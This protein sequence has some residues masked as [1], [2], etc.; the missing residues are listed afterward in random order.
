LEINKKNAGKMN[1]WILNHYAATPDLATGTRHYDFGMELS[2]RGHNITVFAS[3]FLPTRP[4]EKCP[5]NRDK[6]L[7]EE[8]NNNFRFV[9]VNTFKYEKNNWK[10]IANMLSYS[11]RVPEVIK[12]LNLTKPDIIV[13]SSVHLFAVLTA[14]LLSRKFGSYFVMEVRDLWPVSLIDMGVSRWHPFIILLGLLERFLYKKADKIVV[15]PPK[16]NE[17][18]ESL[19]IS[20]N[21]IRW[22]PNGV[23]LSRFNINSEGDLNKNNNEFIV[24]YAGALGTANNLD[25]V[26]DS[27]GILKPKY[28]NVKFVF[29]GEG[30]EKSK[31]IQKAKLLKLDNVE[32]KNPV[33]KEEISGLLGKADVL[34]FNLPN[35]AV[36]KYGISSNKLFDY[37]AS[38]KPIIFSCNSINN[39]VDEADA[40]ITVPPSN[41]QAL[42]EAV[43]KL[44]N[45]PVYQRQEMGKRGK[46][47]VRKYHDIPI[48]V[49]RMEEVFKEVLEKKE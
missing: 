35:L 13:G 37:L 41:P 2:K 28:P 5:L 16:A 39:P 23:D 46:E 12:S 1:I 19:G 10:R 6:Y 24:M 15:L 43:I 34:F 42:T 49:D 3:G 11:R 44:H 14:Y 32:F 18:I 26:I 9:W 40:G 36:F 30:I 29:V 22:V 7:I 25:I 45:I 20:A 31:L 38:G 27:A 33:K 48:L 17:Y 21:K 4:T 8:I 47:Y